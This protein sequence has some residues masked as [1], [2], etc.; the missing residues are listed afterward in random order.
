MVWITIGV[1]ALAI[2]EIFGYAPSD[3]TPFVSEIRQSGTCPFV[4]KTC[5]KVFRDGGII[6]GTCSVKPPSSE[7]VVCCPKRMYAENFKI[8]RDVA[9]EVFGSN[10]NLIPPADVKNTCGQHGRVVAFGGGWGK[11]L[12]VPK[13]EGKKGG[14]SADWILVLLQ[15]D[16]D[17]AE[18]VAIEVQ[19]M[20]TTGSYQQA[21]CKLMGV[22]YSPTSG[23]V[24]KR[25]GSINWENV[26]KRILP[27]LIT[28]G[29]VFQREALCKK[30]LF[31]IT[32]TPVYKRVVER[33]GTT[34]G[35]VPLQPS[36]ITFRHY[37]LGM[38][39]KPG[40]IKPLV[41]QGQYTTTVHHLRDAFFSTLNLPP[42][43]TI[44]GKIRDALKAKAKLTRIKNE[45]EEPLISG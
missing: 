35:D 23:K 22:P 19:S 7:E 38:I 26:N 5:I 20:D 17:L 45:P 14:Y 30:G 25:E 24:G 6:N 18:F 32:P 28:K 12:R 33:L 11:E 44:T 13:G 40:E 27:Q 31:F 4:Q 39:A 2:T 21:W 15:P 43:G 3:S 34:P 16:D 10:A 9:V 1:M 36:A 41:F 37:E 42:Q 8:I 29:L